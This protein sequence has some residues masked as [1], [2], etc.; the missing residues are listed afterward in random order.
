MSMNRHLPAAR[1]APEGL[2]PA[3][4]Y[5]ADAPGTIWASNQILVVNA[6]RTVLRELEVALTAEG[7]RVVGATSFEGAAQ[8]LV[9]GGIELVVADVRLG[10]FNGLHLA[11]RCR[12][13]GA[14]RP[15]IITHDA[16]DP[17]F[18]QE[19]TSLG[20]V[21]VAAPLHDDTLVRTVRRTIGSP[22]RTCHIAGGHLA[23]SS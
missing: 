13:D 20:A 8:A 11:A 7:Y 18:E 16:P 23:A 6:D 22:E 17:W 19:A 12:H 3:A 1:P 21:F 15:V 10:P 4:G 5:A 2:L 14:R 9:D